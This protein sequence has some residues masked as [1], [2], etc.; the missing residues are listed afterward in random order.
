MLKIGIL[1][2]GSIARKMAATISEMESAC[3]YGAASREE[4]RAHKFAQEYKIEKAYDGYESMVNDP[5]IDLIYIATPHTLHYE[6]IKLCLENRKHV[7]C[8]KPFTVNAGQAEEMF[9]MAD[10]KGC[11]VTEAMWTRYMPSRKMIESMIGEGSIGEIQSLT[12]NLGY[13]LLGVQRLTDPR[14]AG[15]AL[16]DLGIYLI[17]FARMIFGTEI[18]NVQASCVLHENGV[19]MSDSITLEFEGGRMAVLHSGIGSVFNRK[20]VLF[21]EKGYMEITNVNNPENVEV[22]DQRDRLIG[23][24]L[25]PV[26]ITGLEY[27]VESCCRAIQ[28][29]WKECPE[30]PHE[31]TVD[32][33]KMMDDMR[34]GWGM[35][36]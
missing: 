10:K 26:Q 20:G 23:Q 12:A 16:L 32:V 6:H 30:L 5:A 15:G 14:L 9:E 29:G 2:T 3:V 25:P 8:E 28:N 35:R 31:E 11:F 18:K 17:H 27:E 4:G 13:P 21:G 24:K 36:Y 22:Y 19:D 34:K 1:G 33:L 7:L